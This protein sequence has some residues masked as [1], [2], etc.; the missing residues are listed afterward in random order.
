MFFLHNI[1]RQSGGADEQC[2]GRVLCREGSEVNNG[3][4]KKQRNAERVK[5]KDEE[6]VA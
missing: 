1:V 5:S 4:K 2:W 3:T 6:D